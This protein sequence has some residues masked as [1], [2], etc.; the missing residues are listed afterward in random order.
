MPEVIAKKASP[1]CARQVAG[2]S[3]GEDV[4][5]ECVSIEEQPQHLFLPDRPGTFSSV[6]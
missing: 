5:K 2:A 3:I 4:P 1:G 6:A